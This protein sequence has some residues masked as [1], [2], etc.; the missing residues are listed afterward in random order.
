MRHAGKRYLTLCGVA[1][2]LLIGTL[3]AQ[4]QQTLRIGMQD[5]PDALDPA[6]GGTFAGRIVFASLCDKLIGFV[7]VPDGLIRP[8]GLT[9]R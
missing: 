6:Q 3:P 8:Q 9:P 1:A 4:A 5:D 7:P 2:M